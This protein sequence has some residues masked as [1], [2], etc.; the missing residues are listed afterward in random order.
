MCACVRACVRARARAYRCACRTARNVLHL[1]I[2][3]LLF[4][5]PVS[6]YLKSVPNVAFKTL[7]VSSDHSR[8]FK[9]DSRSSTSVFYTSSSPLGDRWPDGL[10]IM[11]EFCV[12]SS[13]TLH[14]GSSSSD[15]SRHKQL[16]MA[17]LAANLPARSFLFT[18]AQPGLSTH[19]SFP[20]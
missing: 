6:V 2:T 8:P 11:L 1:D 4:F 15:L 20:R 14:R 12:S 9:K 7:T 19:S 17:A 3:N 10:G 13:A 16:V 18:P 5:L